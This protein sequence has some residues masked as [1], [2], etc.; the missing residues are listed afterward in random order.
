MLFINVCGRDKF[1]IK[2]A[3]LTILNQIFN[4]PYLCYHC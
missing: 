1:E 4:E 3:K 2:N